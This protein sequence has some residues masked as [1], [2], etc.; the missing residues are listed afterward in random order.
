VTILV[1][2]MRMDAQ[3]SLLGF[4]TDWVNALAEKCGK[5]IVLTLFKGDIETAD[6]VQVFGLGRESGASRAQ[7]AYNFYKQLFKIGKEER[8]DGCFSHMIPRLT[9]LGGPWLRVKAIPLV[10]WYSHQHTLS[11]EQRLA[12]RLSK[13]VLTIGAD[14]YRSSDQPKKVRYVGHGI[15]LHRFECT[16]KDQE[17]IKLLMVT[18]ISPVKD[19][20]VAIEALT[21]LP[22][23]LQWECTIAGDCPSGH[24]CY[25]KKIK[26]MIVERE[27]SR[28]VEFIGGVAHSELPTLHKR[29]NIHI[30]SSHSLNKANLEAMASG[31][32]PCSP[33]H[34]LMA[35]MSASTYARGD[36]KALANS[37]RRVCGMTVTERDALAA[38]ASR[39]VHQRFSLDKMAQVIM[40]EFK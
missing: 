39:I 30:D 19:I 34:E 12:H 20:E 35:G 27:L 8:I 22:I 14:T 1:F 28:R 16:K 23:D 5:V 3:D 36:S 40:G 9:C 37:I 25:E 4:T 18:R 21:L 33:N 24:E 10:Q 31:L 11:W 6:N 32:I 17:A 15:P 38:L 2:N 26:K 29:H 13:R 7:V